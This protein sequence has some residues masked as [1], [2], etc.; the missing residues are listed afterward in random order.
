MKTFVLCWLFVAVLVGFSGILRNTA[1]PIP[2]FCLAMTLTLLAVLAVSRELRERALSTGIRGLVAVH[3][4]RFFGI[5]FLW[6]SQQGLVA[7]DFAVLAGWGPIIIAIGALLI[8]IALRP[9]DARGR[10][11]ILIWNVI[12]LLDVALAFAVMAQ[13]A[14][15][16]PL[17]QGGFAS[18][19]LSLLPTFI[20]PLIIVSHA[21]IFVWWFRQR[22]KDH[23]R[24]TENT[25]NALT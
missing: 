8:L 20:V 17:L 19:P 12:G 7:R 23:H 21:L 13:M 9:D 4:L 25:G 16:D 3:L 5:Y 18:L 14:R 22:G 24:D 2:A 1:L 11:A 6:L 10:Q 15:P